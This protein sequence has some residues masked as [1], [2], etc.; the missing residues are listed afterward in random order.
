MSYTSRLKLPYIHSGQAQKEI[1]H[2]EALTLL[3][4]LINP[5]VEATQVTMPPQDATVGQLYIVSQNPQ[6]EFISHANKIAQKLEIGWKFI[7]APKW[8]EVTL[9]SNG[10]KYRFDGNSWI[11]S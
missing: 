3:D 6:G 7:T 10:S 8:L 5:V 4:I 9:D 2:N 11:K 1:T